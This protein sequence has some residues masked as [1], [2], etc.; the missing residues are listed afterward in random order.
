MEFSYTARNKNGEI[1]VGKVSAASEEAAAD[2]LQKTELFVTH[3][4]KIEGEKSIY[5][6]KLRIFQRVSKKDVVLFSRQLSILINSD[7]PLVEALN[8]LVAQVENIEF[9]DK[10]KEISQDVEGGMSFSQALSYQP[11]IFSSFFISL[12]KSGEASGKLSNVLAYLADHLEREYYLMSKI[13]GAM[14]YPIFV[15]ATII[16]V[17]IVMVVFVLPQLIGV[18]TESGVQLP[19]VTRI[20]ISIVNFLKTQGWIIILGL[21][22]IISIIIWWLKTPKGKKYYDDISL[23]VPVIGNLTKLIYLSRFAENLSTLISGGIPIADALNITGDVVDNSVYKD[24]VIK[25]R[26]GVRKGESISSF[27]SNFPEEIPPIFTQ[28]VMVGEKTGRLD[29][30]LMNISSFYQKEIDTFV[31]NALTLIEP[32]MMVIMGFVV[33]FFVISFLLPLYQGMGSM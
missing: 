5:A 1:Q 2:L 16:L 31:E 10:I 24:I 23:R 20:L 4:E 8:T 28:M 21:A 9:K 22:I 3:L 19:L 27:L 12:V 25:T 29:S 15:L 7:V 30:I 14:V 26:D 32:V 18:L 17:L 13:R 6:S 11:K 33:G